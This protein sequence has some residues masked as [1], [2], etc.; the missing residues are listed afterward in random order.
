MSREQ[1]LIVDDDAGCR[2]ALRDLLIPHGYCVGEA[3][4]GQQALDLIASQPPDLVL[5]DLEMP[6][7]NGFAVCRRIKADPR[8]RLIPVVIVTSLDWVPAKVMALEACA[9]DYLNKPVNVLEL[10]AR[11]G[12]LLSLKRFTDEL[13]NASTVLRGIARAVEVRD[14]YTGGHGIRVGRAAAALGKSL[15]LSEEDQHALT[16]GAQLH[17]IG[18]IGIPDSI[19]RKAGPLTPEEQEVMR[20]HP[21]IGADLCKPMRTME[22][23]IPIIRSHH[24]R[25]DGSGYPEGLSGVQ[26]SLLVRIVSVV[27][28][29]DALTTAR[30]YRPAMDRDA[31]LRT[32]REEVANGWWDGG[33][34][35]TWT[36][37]L[38][39][40]R[41]AVQ[42]A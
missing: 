24:E 5:L 9:D 14:V 15:G 33:V 1:I 22:K 29:Y 35:Q 42:T 8:T 27:D 23:V 32:L 11:I 4:N 12:S 31:A 13:E 7:L 25:L 10:M 37:L 17:D 20:T 41:L 19:L 38:Q 6:G 3:K 28:V 26:V 40:R 30:A 2:R 39:Q 21:A 34:V 36:E 18:K 16:L